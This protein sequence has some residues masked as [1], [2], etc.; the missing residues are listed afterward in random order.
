MAHVEG[1]EFPEHLLYDVE[2]QL[3]YAPLSDGTVRVGYTAWAAARMGEVLV[4]TPK[5][6]GHS[7][8][9]NRWLAMVEAGKWIGAARAA[10]D[11][12]IVAHN[13]TLVDRPRLLTTDA[14]GAGWM[15]IVRPASDD[16]RTGLV[17]GAE[18][19]ATIERW[20]A[21]GSYKDHAG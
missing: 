21:G 19:G 8:E 13:Q 14:F 17:T 18:V 10:F 7:F 9:K 4:F 5:R 12:I 2:N 1:Y 16:W 3:W 6:I 20:I 11:G 15:I